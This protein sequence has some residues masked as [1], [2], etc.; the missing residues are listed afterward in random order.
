MLHLKML[1]KLKKHV[2]HV[3]QAPQL[4]LVQKIKIVDI[5]LEQTRRNLEITVLDLMIN[6]KMPAH[7]KKDCLLNSSINIITR[8]P[9]IANLPFVISE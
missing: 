6:Y 1:I 9:I 5:T 2:R 3:G 4:D 7:S 8:K